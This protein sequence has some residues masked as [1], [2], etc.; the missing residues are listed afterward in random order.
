MSVGKARWGEGREKGLDG[1]EGEGRYNYSYTCRDIIT[2]IRQI[3]RSDMCT[4]IC[5]FVVRNKTKS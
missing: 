2:G 1:E 4:Y 5:V 3:S